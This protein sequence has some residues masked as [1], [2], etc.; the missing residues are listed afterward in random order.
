MNTK[1]KGSRR[2]IFLILTGERSCLFQLEFESDRAI[3]FI[4]CARGLLSEYAERLRG[5]RV[6]PTAPVA[7][8]MEIVRIWRYQCQCG[9]FALMLLS[10]A[11]VRGEH[12]EIFFKQFFI[13]P[14]DC[15]RVIDLSG[16]RYRMQI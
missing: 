14:G 7:A 15:Y 8:L 10:A 1:A 6:I 3:F 12:F 16:K 2:H 5:V 9:F 4:I 13:H 11:F